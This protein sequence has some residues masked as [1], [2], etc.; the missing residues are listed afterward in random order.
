YSKL[1][2]STQRNIPKPLRKPG[3][4]DPT[5]MQSHSET[6][7]PRPIH[8]LSKITK[9]AYL[10]YPLSQRKY[11]VCPAPEPQQARSL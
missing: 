7:Y 4:P 3:P 8:Q 2:N 10:G 5:V 1:L 6:V 9:S 11:P